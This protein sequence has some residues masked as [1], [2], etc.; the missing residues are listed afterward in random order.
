LHQLRHRHQTARADEHIGFAFTACARPAATRLGRVAGSSL[1]LWAMR[2]S[3][4]EPYVGKILA[5]VMAWRHVPALEFHRADDGAVPPE[6]RHRIGIGEGVPLEFTYDPGA[7][8]RIRGDR[9]ADVKGIEKAVGRARVIARRQVTRNIRA[10][11]IV[12]SSK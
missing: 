9:L 8:A 2:L 11:W 3:L 7:L 1:T 10:N 12:G 6:K 4:L 5:D